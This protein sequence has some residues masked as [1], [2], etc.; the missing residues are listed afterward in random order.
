MKIALTKLI[1]G[2][3]GQT[4]IIAMILML[5]GALIIAPLLGFMSTGLLAGQVFETKMDELYAADAGV[6]DGLWKILNGA[7]GVPGVGDPPL[8][9]IIADINSKEVNVTVER[10]DDETYKITSIADG[11]TIESYIAIINVLID[12]ETY[13]DYGGSG[14]IVDNIIVPPGDTVDGNI[15]GDAQVWGDGDLTVTGNFEGNAIVNIV[16]D[17]NLSGSGN[18]LGDTIVRV[19]GDMT[20]NGNIEGNAEVYVSGNLT[21]LGNIAGSA[22]VGVG[23][24]LYVDGNIDQ[25]V[26]VGGTITVGGNMNAANLGL[27]N[28]PFDTSCP[29]GEDVATLATWEIN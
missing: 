7:A 21:V 20:I 28:I 22:L 15:L 9:Y 27:E 25:D 13:G 3:K 5:V 24:D 23:G 12:E 6:E 8:V 2:E 1:R 26:Y 18:I 11:T 10:I 17:V 14:N 4:L 29:L 16:G 19:F